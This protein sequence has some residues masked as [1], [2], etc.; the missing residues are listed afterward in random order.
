MYYNYTVNKN[1]L[2]YGRKE[3][4]MSYFAIM[5]KGMKTDY[6]TN[7]NLFLVSQWIFDMQKKGYT[8]FKRGSFLKV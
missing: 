4:T 1:C 7:E 3:S 6:F 8:V 5:K 2:P